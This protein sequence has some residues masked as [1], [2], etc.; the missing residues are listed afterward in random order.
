MAQ[1]SD[2]I[3]VLIEALI[4]MKFAQ[5]NPETKDRSV[6]AILIALQTHGEFNAT[7]GKSIGRYLRT[8]A[9]S[10][11]APLPEATALSSAGSD[12]HGI[13]F[14]QDP[15]G[16]SVDTGSDDQKVEGTNDGS[17]GNRWSLPSWRRP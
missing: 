7:I 10:S 8:Q 13:A 16:A 5:R 15:V 2:D 14:L 11:S 4:A 3:D 6:R 9:T 1:F 12:G 17:G